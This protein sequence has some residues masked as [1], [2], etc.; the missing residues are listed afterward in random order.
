MP[1]GC[2]KLITEYDYCVSF[3][4]TSDIPTHYSVWQVQ[5]PG[6]PRWYDWQSGERP[7]VLSDQMTCAYIRLAQYQYSWVQEE[8]EDMIRTGLKNEHSGN[9]CKNYV[10]D[11]RGPYGKYL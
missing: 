2:T 5:F 10:S 1:I 9:V 8:R 4:P 3:Q 11:L 6:D 7:I